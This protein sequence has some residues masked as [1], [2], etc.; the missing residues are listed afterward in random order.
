MTRVTTLP[1]GS[2]YTAVAPDRAM[3]YSGWVE[4]GEEILWTAANS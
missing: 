4:T 2:R 3:D 1:H